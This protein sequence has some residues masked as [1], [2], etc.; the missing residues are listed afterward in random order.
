MLAPEDY[1]YDAVFNAKTRALMDKIVFVHGGPEYDA[2]YPD[3]IPTRV[4]IHTT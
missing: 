2:K 3:G 4:K 1:G